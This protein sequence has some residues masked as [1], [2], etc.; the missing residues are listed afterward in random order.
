MTEKNSTSI[1]WV[2]FTLSYSFPNLYRYT[3]GNPLSNHHVP[4]TIMIMCMFQFGKLEPSYNLIE[5]WRGRDKMAGWE[6]GQ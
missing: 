2:K 1:L 3:R 5:L 4:L 6:A